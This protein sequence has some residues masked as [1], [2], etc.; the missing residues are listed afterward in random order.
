[1]MGTLRIAARQLL[2]N[3]GFT[4]A[5]V[6]TLGLGIGANTAVFSLVNDVLLRTL[7]VK[8]PGELVLFRNIEGQGGRLSRAG[9]NNGS[10]DPRTGRS[11]STSFSFFTLTRFRDNHRALSDVFAY[12]PI[13]QVSVV[14]GGDA[15]TIPLGQLVSGGYYDGLGVSAIA[16]RT[17]SPADDTPAAAPV[18]VISY[19]YWSSRFRRDPATI[20]RTI[21][22]NN[23]A[24][25]VIGVTPSGFM[26]AMQIGESADIT[27]PLSLHVRLLPE[28]AAA[29]AQPYYWWLRIMGR[30]APGVTATA[31]CR[32]P[33]AALSADRARR[34]ARGPRA[35]S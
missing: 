11:A 16:G 9:E 31:G 15:E 25:T 28:R 3:R 35:R 30:L 33:G 19:R 8:N 13:N 7:P 2:H 32:K 27:L 29:R 17:V 22:V 20:G 1:M 6:A 12:A 18:A 24:V 14:I 21:H 5:V 10:I 23:V 4:A 34:L 26:G